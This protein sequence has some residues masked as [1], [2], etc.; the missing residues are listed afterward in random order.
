[1]TGKIATTNKGSFI[2]NGNAVS[3][4]IIKASKVMDGTASISE[5]IFFK[6][7]KYIHKECKH[8]ERYAKSMECAYKKGETIVKV[9]RKTSAK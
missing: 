2:F 6:E 4:R 1:M 7:G 3:D 8:I 5:Q 9:D